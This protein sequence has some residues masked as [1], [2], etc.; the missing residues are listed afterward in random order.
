MRDTER[1][2]QEA[3]VRSNITSRT[4][5]GFLLMA[6]LLAV[7]NL[8]MIFYINRLQTLTEMILDNNVSSLLAA[9]RME[10]A[11]QTQRRRTENFLLT[12]DEAWVKQLSKDRDTF[13][14]IRQ[15]VQGAART[16]E[17]RTVLSRIDVLYEGFLKAQEE[18]ISWY[19]QGRMA[20]ARDMLVG[21]SREQ[22]ETLLEMCEEFSRLNERAIEAARDQMLWDNARAR[23]TIYGI[24]VAGVL[25]G[26]LLGVVIARSVVR[27]IAEL[28]LMVRSAEGAGEVVERLELSEGQALESLGQGV[29]SLMQKIKSV[30]ADLARSE[31]MLVQA[32]K[33]A[34]AGQFAA[35]IA[36]EIR[37][38]LTAIKTMI[39]AL[40]A[41]LPPGD[42]R[43]VDFDVV[44]G[45]LDQM[46]RSLQRLLDFTRPQEPAFAPVRL[47]RPL[48]NAVT[49][50][51]SKAQSQGVQVEVNP[52]PG[53]VIQADQRQ[54]EQVFVNLMLNALQAMPEG[55]KIRI[56]AGV[57]GQ[58]S[59]DGEAPTPDTRSPEVGRWVEVEVADT[60]YGIPEELLGRIFEPFV[61]GRERGTGLG[62]AIVRKVVE[63]HGGRIVAQNRPEGGAMFTVAL[64]LKEDDG[65]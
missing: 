52:D 3:C 62:L 29:E 55:G 36:H 31:K 53:I 21:A 47:D 25:I 30:S 51:A 18:A 22:A 38:P 10:G 26:G 14:S 12:G 57:R 23:R 58:G 32:E 64:P 13:A 4:V 42:S 15:R 65:T 46:E 41:D 35:G 11:I 19:R 2:E 1:L 5:A 59:G 7:V 54:M 16:P 9:E 24:A 28:V 56:K 44:S 43:R 45:E 20:V 34:V 50:L 61:T 33:L 40:C 60:G 48:A 49:L 6:G 8:A 17:E 39:F 37:N 63:Q 27:P